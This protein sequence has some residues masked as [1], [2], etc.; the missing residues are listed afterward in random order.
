MPNEQS[1]FSHFHEELN[2]LFQNGTISRRNCVVE[3]I[4]YIFLQAIFT[5]SVAPVMHYNQQNNIFP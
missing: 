5:S 2:F 1:Y 3:S 4:Y